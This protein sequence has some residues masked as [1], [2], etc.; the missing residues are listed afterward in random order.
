MPATPDAPVL[1]LA[2][3][4]QPETD[5]EVRRS[6]FLARAARTDTEAEA[7][8]L[9]A[10]VRAEHPTARHHCSA[11]V[12]GVPSALPVERSNDDGEPSGT[13]GQPILEVLRGTGLV[14]VSVVV[15]RYFGGTLLGTGGLVRAYSQAA[16]Q[17]LD[18]AR[19]ARLVT[20]H[21]W[22][23]RVPVGEAGRLEADLRALA[24]PR[25][26][27]LSVEETVWG[28][29]HAVLMLSTD[30]PDADGLSA[31]LASVSQGSA[32]P[33]AAGSRVVEQPC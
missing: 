10:E 18:A 8:A 13:A 29:T 21:L 5:L 28:A 3:G 32:V 15:T 22:D 12:I 26:G 31:L 14:G 23:V 17:A 25:D 19:R 2:R 16:A 4:R 1:T 11:F 7:R 20:R 9:I 30:S 6:H 33:Q 24:G 27:A